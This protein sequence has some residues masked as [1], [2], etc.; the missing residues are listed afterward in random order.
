MAARMAVKVAKE[1]V[2]M[3]VLQLVEVDVDKVVKDLV[4]DCATLIV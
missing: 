4:I 1:A 2:K 3:A